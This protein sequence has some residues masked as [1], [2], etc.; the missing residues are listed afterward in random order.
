MSHSTC[1]NG[2]A[3]VIEEILSLQSNPS[4][5]Q[6][7]PASDNINDDEIDNDEDDNNNSY[8]NASIP[9]RVSTPTTFFLGNVSNLYALWG[10]FSCRQFAH[11]CR[12]L[13]LLIFEPEDRQLLESP[14]VFKSI[15]LLQLRQNR[16]A[17]AGRD[18]TVNMNQSILLGD[19]ILIKR[20][21]QLLAIM[22][23][24]PP[25]SQ[26]S[27][28][29]VMTHFPFIADTL[30]MMGL[31]EFDDWNDVD[32]LDKIARK[33]LISTSGIENNENNNNNNNNNNNIPR[34]L[35]DL[36]SVTEMLENLSSSFNNGGEHINQLGNIIAV[37][38]AAQQ[39]GVVA[40]RARTNELDD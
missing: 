35:H 9:S 25:L 3:A 7:Q 14:A 8:N 19:E 16:A 2:A 6:Q 17:R 23:F 4:Q 30:M 24:G 1:F 20:L 11:F 28:F 18:S 26:P 15:E 22:N 33:L 37:I 40:G 27:S 10:N 21:L 38:S 5:P 34:Q 32:R 31:K 36:G 29:H 13:A 12:I 39:A